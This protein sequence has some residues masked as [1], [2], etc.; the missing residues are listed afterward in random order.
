MRRYLT[1]LYAKSR[2]CYSRCITRCH[3]GYSP[4]TYPDRLMKPTKYFRV[5][6]DSAGIQTSNPQIYV[7]RKVVACV[8]LIDDGC[9]CIEYTQES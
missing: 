1:L 5:I 7:V 8:T 2:V 6:S 4:G 9:F 3:I